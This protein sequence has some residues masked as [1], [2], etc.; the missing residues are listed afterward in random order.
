[1]YGMREQDNTLEWLPMFVERE[2]EPSA[3]EC[4]VE[5]WLFCR[6]LTVRP[7]RDLP[8]DVMAAEYNRILRKRMTMNGWD[9]EDAA[10][11][12]LIKFFDPAALPPGS[13]TRRG[14]IKKDTAL[15]FCRS[16]AG[17]LTAVADGSVLAT[18]SSQK[19]CEAV[20]DL[21]LGENPVCKK[22]KLT[23]GRTLTEML[24]QPLSARTI[25]I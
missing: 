17:T 8:L 21:Y 13:T 18:V 1:M 7:A 24:T 25:K 20:F 3:S 6:S 4:S 5:R 16:K 11:K 14:H 10:L 22:A 2:L 12:V 23:A 9:P 15:S 19:L